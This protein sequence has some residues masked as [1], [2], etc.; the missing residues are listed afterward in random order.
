[1][2][3]RI[4]VLGASGLVGRQ[5]VRMLVNEGRDVACATR[6]PTSPR[7]VYF[8]LLDPAAFGQ[9]LDGTSTVMLISRPGD[10]DAHLH[11][12]AFIDAMRRSGV[13]RVVV[14]S[15]LGAELRPEFSLRKVELLVEDSGMRWTHVR[16]NFFMQMLALPPLATEIAARGTLSLP[17]AG[18]AVAYV[19]ARDVAAVLHRALVDDTLAGQGITLNG[20]E[21][22]NHFQIAASISQVTGRPVR[23]LQLDEPAAREMMLTRGF[24]PRHVERVLAFYRLIRN[25]FCSQPDDHASTLLGRPLRTWSEFVKSEAGSWKAA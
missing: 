7:D 13:E 20:P 6:K 15:A 16:P 2:S 5:V 11:A 21:A 23:Y 4:L 24:A 3:K 19:D 17:L 25:G 8:D 1:M 18:A 12:R 9:S 10:E 22:L 14:L